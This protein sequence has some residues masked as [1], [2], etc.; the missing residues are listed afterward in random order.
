MPHEEYIR[1]VSGGDTAVLFIHGILG[2]PDHFRGLIPL[3]PESWSVHNILLDGHG[4]TVQDFAKASMQA[5]KEQ[6]RRETETLAGRYENIIIAAHS[7]GTLLAIDAA[8]AF[9]NQ[10]SRLFLLAVPLKIFV[11]PSALSSSMKV[12]FNRVSPDDGVALAA[13]EAYSIMPSKRLWNYIKW[14][15]R[16]LELFREARA[17]QSVVGSLQ[18]PCRVFQSGKDELVSRRSC[19]FLKRNPEITLSVLTNSGHFYYEQA[20]F[21]YL[22]HEFWAACH[23]CL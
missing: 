23:T 16:Y 20:D 17:A 22:Q 13:K 10:V 6:V 14:L 12:V 1:D 4:G 9:P 8:L 11:K 19:E 15:P 21:E 5:W 18:L 7:M 3:I 2:T